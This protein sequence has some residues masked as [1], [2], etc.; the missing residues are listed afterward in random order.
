MGTV[1]SRNAKRLAEDV[2]EGVSGVV[3]VNNQL[4]VNQETVGNQGP[5]A[6]A[7]PGGKGGREGPHSTRAA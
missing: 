7:H 3:D 2:A 6:Q 1:S 4:R 5:A